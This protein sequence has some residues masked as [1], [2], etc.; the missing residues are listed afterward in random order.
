MGGKKS[1]PE[2]FTKTP[3]SHAIDKTDSELLEYGANRTGATYEFFNKKDKNYFVFFISYLIFI[4][5]LYK[6][7]FMNKIKIKLK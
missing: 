3:M 5:L 2:D 6:Y 7:M 1:K 4:L